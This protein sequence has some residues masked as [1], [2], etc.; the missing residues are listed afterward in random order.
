MKTMKTQ[1]L[2]ALSALAALLALAGCDRNQERSAGQ[3]LDSAIAK[4]DAASERAKT[5]GA[6]A[7]AEF[8]DAGEKA[9]Q[10]TTD[11]AAKLSEKLEDAAITA[12]VT[13][14][15]AA[16]KDL[17]ATR[18]KVASRDGVVTL[19][20]PVPSAA[21]KERAAEIARNVKGVSTVNNQ[22]TVQS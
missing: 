10:L 21:A 5:A 1:S 20:G 4:A 15:L 9:A 14:G 2:I 11:A 12:K 7:A 19:K 8:K 6:S 22:L 13:T 3:Q 18:I 17:S 16:D